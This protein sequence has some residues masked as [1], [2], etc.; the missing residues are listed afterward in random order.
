[1]NIGKL[2]V[3]E[4]SDGAGK[5]TQLSLLKN[6]LSL[7]N[8][9]FE[10]LDFP[11]YDT[12][13]FGEWIGRFLSGEFGNLSQIPPYLLAFPYAADRW[14]AKE[15]LSKWLRDGKIVL[16]NRYTPSNAVYQGAKLPEEKREAFIRWVF[17]MEYDVFKI[18]KEDLVVYL[19]VPLSISEKLIDQKTG[20][21]YLQNGSTK[22][23]HESNSALLENVEKIYL[24]MA[25]KQAH[26]VKIECCQEN[27]MLDELVISKKLIQV[28]EKKGMIRK[29]SSK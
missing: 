15:Q 12:T 28:L 27:S 5:T 10:I 17:E 3:I 8:V 1:M 13:F 14:Q 18:P 7:K 6:Y 9:A 25:Q 11:Q 21:T 23:L 19:H 29:S 2:I 20:R 26:W 4:G 16:T 22:D 24:E